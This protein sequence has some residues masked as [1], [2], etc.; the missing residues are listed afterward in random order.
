MGTHHQLGHRVGG[1]IVPSAAV[2]ERHQARS[3]ELR[4]DRRRTVELEEVDHGGHDVDRVDSRL[5]GARESSIRPLDDEGNGRL[6]AI[7]GL[8]VAEDRAAVHRMF[9]EGLAVIR[10]EEDHAVVVDGAR[11]DRRSRPG[12]SA[13]G[14]PRPLGVHRRSGPA[15]GAGPAAR[16][17]PPGHRPL[18]RPLGDRAGRRSGHPP[19]RRGGRRRLPPRPGGAR[20]PGAGGGADGGLRP[21]PRAAPSVQRRPGAR[22]FGVNYPCRLAMEVAVYADQDPRAVP[23]VFDVLGEAGRRRPE[24]VA[25]RALALAELDRH[26]EAEEALEPSWRRAQPNSALTLY[27][28]RGPRE[29]FL[30]PPEG[31]PH[32]AEG[33]PPAAEGDPHRAEGVPSPPEGDPHRTGG[34][35]RL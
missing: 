26:G 32:R 6:L 21:R 8:P 5:D 33:D 29:A 15:V 12:G 16:A 28:I 35:Q 13:G 4:G 14:G 18:V 24:M 1:G 2:E 10:R 25:H 34:R 20:A 7:E 27:E 17:A 9:A 11:S 19:P 23:A 30:R 3:P 22:L 31:D